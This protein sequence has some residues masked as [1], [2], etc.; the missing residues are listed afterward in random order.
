M[1]DQGQK[2]EQPTQ[3]RV[4]KARHD[5][6]LPVAERRFAVA[7]K[8]LLD[9]GPGR[10]LDLGIGIGERELEPLRQASANT[11]LADAHQSHKCDRLRRAKWR[12]HRC[13]PAVNRRSSVETR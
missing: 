13:S 8:D 4:K 3:R 6:A 9:A 1:A 12:D 5:A 7:L 2:T 11:C 10:S